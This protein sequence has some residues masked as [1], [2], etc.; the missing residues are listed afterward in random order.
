MCQKNM[1]NEDIM[2]AFLAEQHAHLQASVQSSETEL[3]LRLDEANKLSN[4]RA[5]EGAQDRHVQPQACLF[6]RVSKLSMCLSASWHSHTTHPTRTSIQDVGHPPVE[7]PR[8]AWSTHRRQHRG[9]RRC[10]RT[11][12]CKNFS[13]ICCNRK[14]LFALQNTSVPR[15]HGNNAPNLEDEYASR[16]IQVHHL[17]TLTFSYSQYTQQVLKSIILL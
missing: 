16:R 2:R 5:Q 10:L 15:N 4:E 13:N 9:E 1:F 14:F 11:V 17:D 7:L 6:H 8:S 12:D 3:I